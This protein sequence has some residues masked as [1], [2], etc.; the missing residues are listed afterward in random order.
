MNLLPVVAINNVSLTQV[1]LNESSSELDKAKELGI[2]LM[3]KDEFVK[4]IMKK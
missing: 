1:V 2:K 4:K 3:E